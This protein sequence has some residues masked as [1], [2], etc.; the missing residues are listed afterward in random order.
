MCRD[1]SSVKIS[2]K[3]NNFCMFYRAVNCLMEKV[4][5]DHMTDE[6]EDRLLEIQYFIVRDFR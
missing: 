5:S 1:F 4:D 2:V 6:C 3:A